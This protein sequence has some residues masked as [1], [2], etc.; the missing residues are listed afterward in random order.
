MC[1]CVWSVFFPGKC[2]KGNSLIL[3]FVR[4]F[5]PSCR[6]YY[7]T[8]READYKTIFANDSNEAGKMWR[9]EYILRVDDS[10]SSPDRFNSTRACFVGSQVCR[11]VCVCVHVCMHRDI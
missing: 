3:F 5:F 8:M 10:S 2:D 4:T 9:N 6:D 7:F 11:F 1:V